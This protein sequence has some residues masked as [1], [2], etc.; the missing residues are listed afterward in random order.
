VAVRRRVFAACLAGLLSLGARSGP[1]GTA[2]ADIPFQLVDGYVLVRAH[3]NGS[4][5]IT[6]LFDTGCGQLVLHSAAARRLGLTAKSTT[7]HD[8][9]EPFVEQVIEGVR[10]GIGELALPP[11]D[12]L[13][14]DNDLLQRRL[15]LEVDGVIGADLLRDFVVGIDYDR[16]RF[17]LYDGNGFV[18]HGPG[19]GLDIV[20]TRHFAT[21]VATLLLEDGEVLTGRFLID[22][23]AGVS[24]ALNTPFVDRYDL[25]QRIGVERIRYTVA[26]QSVEMTTHPGRIARFTLGDLGFDDLP[27]LLSQTETGP[28]SPS[29]IAGII[30][31][32]V[33]T[34]FN[35][36]Y[37]YKRNKL[38]LEPS[39]LH[40]GPFHVDASGLAIAPAASGGFVVRAVF[41]G[42]P[43]AQ[44]G[45]L[46]GDM[47]TRIDGTDTSALATHEVRELL[48]R[49]GETAALML[50]R[51]RDSVEVVLRLKRLY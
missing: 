7:R 17:T 10:L 47:I 20:S 5:T 29:V 23:G 1:H 11:L 49:D 48:A 19:T 46:V 22:T 13:Q 12:A 33:W 35:T 31:N 25:L 6:L 24:V 39:R 3:V 4:D 21:T 51:D 2:L 32:Q 45:V 9:R 34:R 37:D 40:D 38:Y 15:G 14:R 30:G 43:A 16:L 36:T 42:S 27:V 26:A 18:Y 41:E 50:D 28:L 44:A 8:G